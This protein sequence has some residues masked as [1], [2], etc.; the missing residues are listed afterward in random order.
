MLYILLLT[1]FVALTAGKESTD[2]TY[3]SKKIC[4]LLIIFFT[5]DLPFR[6]VGGTTVP[7]AEFPYQ[8]SIEQEGYHFCGGAIVSKT[9]IVTAAHCFP[10]ILGEGK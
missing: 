10:N 1:F 8:V 2:G 4:Q 7:V 5:L 9:Y 6:I 3:C